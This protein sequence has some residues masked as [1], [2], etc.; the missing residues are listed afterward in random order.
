MQLPKFGSVTVGS[1]AADAG[2]GGAAALRAPRLL[3]ASRSPRRKWLLEE[4]GIPFIAEHPGFDDSG[5]HPGGLI[6]RPQQWVCYLAYV[7]AWARFLELPD[8]TD[9]D[10]VL[11]SDTACVMDERLIGTPQSEGEAREMIRAFCGR[12]HGVVSGVALI[13]T[14]RTDGEPDYEEERSKI[15]L[16][17]PRGSRLLFADSAVVRMGNLSHDVL[18][19]YLASGEWRGK[20]G[21]YNLLDRIEAGWPLTYEGDPT[22]IMGLPMR[23]LLV[24]LE[25]FARRGSLHVRGRE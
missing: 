19:E 3:L 12:E 11:G 22:T 1:T 15:Q 8:A 24:R 10:L 21:G 20:A 4:A 7:K 2:G 17:N 6:L 25:Q 16:C 9:V 14:G 18:E 13:S 23:A 5:M